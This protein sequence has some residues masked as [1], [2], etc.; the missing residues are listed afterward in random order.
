MEKIRIRIVPA[1]F[2]RLGI[3]CLILIALGFR[4]P[5]LED[6]SI[7]HASTVPSNTRSSAG[8]NSEDVQTVPLLL[9]VA[10]YNIHSCKGLDFK[11]ECNRIAEVLKGTQADIIGLEEV[12]QGQEEEI[13]RLLGFNVV[14]GRADH[15]HGYEFGNA[16][17]S[18]FPIR[19][20]HIYLIDV[21]N[22]QKRACL[23]AD[24]AWPGEGQMLHVFV[25]HLG[26]DSAE[27]REQAER[28]ASPEILLDPSLQGA[29][30]I[31]LGDFNEKERNGEVNARLTPILGRSGA[32]SWPAFAAIVYLD[33][34]YFSSDLKLKSVRAYGGGSAFI[35]SDHAPLTAV[36]ERVPATGSQ[37]SAR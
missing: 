4:Q 37:S 10:T 15:V 8:S 29:P 33:R 32:R 9:H 35:A 5:H 25:V 22:R 17:L 24:V 27:R 19:D 21:P 2:V 20:S 6:H 23:R 1:L 28:L 12:R 26:L 36:L 3:A 16:V 30:R 13:A 14:F 7:I 11:F 34:V 31:L 18:R